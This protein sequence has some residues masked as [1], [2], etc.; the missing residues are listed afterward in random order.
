MQN[1]LSAFIRVHLWQKRVC[2]YSRA[3]AVQ[4]VLA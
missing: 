3:F 2:P 4:V 1:G